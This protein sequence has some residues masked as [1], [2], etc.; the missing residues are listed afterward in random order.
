MKKYL[1]VTPRALA[2]RDDHWE[3]FS[4]NITRQVRFWKPRRMLNAR[5]W[6]SGAEEPGV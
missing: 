1:A 2:E 5:C 3:R 4:L 6:K